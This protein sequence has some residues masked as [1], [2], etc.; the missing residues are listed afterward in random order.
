MVYLLI[1][2]YNLLEKVRFYKIIV[3]STKLKEQICT[4]KRL[5]EQSIT[6]WQNKF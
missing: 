2:K 6:I 4:N 1:I 5:I 3:F